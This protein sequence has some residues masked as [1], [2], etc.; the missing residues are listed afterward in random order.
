MHPALGEQSLNHWTAR[1]VLST[2]LV[3]IVTM[4]YITGLIYHILEVCLF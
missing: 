4:L 2:V 1:E 3:T